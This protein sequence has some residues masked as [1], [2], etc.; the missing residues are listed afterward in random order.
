MWHWPVRVSLSSWPCEDW[1]ASLAWGV[2][3]AEQ[4]AP[5]ACG[6]AADAG[7]HPRR[8]DQ[9]YRVTRPSLLRGLQ[10]LHFH[11][12]RAG[13]R[14]CRAPSREVQDEKT[15]ACRLLGRAAARVGVA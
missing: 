10:E 2:F 13:A 4:Q 14:G 15:R 9:R 3:G 1:L 7:C 8:G 5:L 11:F 6:A 12:T